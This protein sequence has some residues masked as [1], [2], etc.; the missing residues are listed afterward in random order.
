MS[1]YSRKPLGI[2]LLL[3]LF[4]QVGSIWFSHRFQ[5]YLA[6]SSLPPR[7]YQVRAT[8][9]GEGIEFNQVLAGYSHKFCAN[10]K[11]TLLASKSPLQLEAFVA[12][13]L[14]TFFF[15]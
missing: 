3:H 13:L 2:I 6:L 15:C 5:V 9:D 14:F 10:I 7:Q 4:E 11:L 12:H 1:K 8:H